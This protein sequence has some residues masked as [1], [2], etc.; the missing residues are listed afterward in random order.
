M[1]PA[2]PSPALS[3][4]ARPPAPRRMTGSLPV[5]TG[6]DGAERQSRAG[7]QCP[8]GP[9]DGNGEDTRRDG[10]DSRGNELVQARAVLQAPAEEEEEEEGKETW[11]EEDEEDLVDHVPPVAHPLLL[12]E[13]LQHA[14]TTPGPEL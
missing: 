3:P 13:E 2:P 7:R 6:R 4:P 5:G 14:E 11:G 8:L 10:G 9:A 12:H 1:S